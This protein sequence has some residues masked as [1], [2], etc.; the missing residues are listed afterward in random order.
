MKCLQDGLTRE[1]AAAHFGCSWQ[2]I[3]AVLTYKRPMPAS[4]VP[5]M[6]T[7]LGIDEGIVGIA[8]GYYPV[9]WMTICR[10]TPEVIHRAINSLLKTLKSTP[11]LRLDP[12]RGKTS[13]QP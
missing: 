9:D 3:L 11:D 7:F 5:K 1:Q 8:F 6:A 12:H 10:E 4:M 13:P 2:F